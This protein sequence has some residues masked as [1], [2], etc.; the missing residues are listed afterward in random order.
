MKIK[1]LA[2]LSLSVLFVSVIALKIVCAAEFIRTDKTL[3]Y[4][5][6]VILTHT[7]DTN[8]FV[9]LTPYTISNSGGK[10][11]RASCRERV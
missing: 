8:Y 9:S 7:V 1:R 6:V 11:G 2:I 3:G 4:N 5:N 10:I